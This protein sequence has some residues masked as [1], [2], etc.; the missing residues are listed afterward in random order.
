MDN[1]NAR[2]LQREPVPVL[3]GVVVFVSFFWCC[4]CTLS[5]APFFVHAF[6][7]LVMTII[8]IWDNLKALPAWVFVRKIVD[9]FFL[10]RFYVRLRN[11]IK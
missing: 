3:G 5:G 6:A 8:G 1:P 2:N 4:G 9:S 10:K 11:L 7:V